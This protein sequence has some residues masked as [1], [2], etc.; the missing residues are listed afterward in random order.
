[1]KR[2]LK[3]VIKRDIEVGDHHRGEKLIEQSLCEEKV[4]IVLDDVDSHEQVDAL[5]S[6]L[7]W[8]GRGRRVIPTT[9]DEHILNVIKID[10][11]KIY[12]PQE[13]DHK[14][15]LQ[16]FRLHAFSRDPPPE[17]YMK[18]SHVECYSGGWPL[19]LEVLG[20]YLLDISG[21]EKWESTLQK[22]KEIPLE[23]VQRRLSY[24]NLED[25]YLKTIFL[26][27]AYFFIG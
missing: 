15:S 5:A 16:L 18:I 2:L 17:D 23:K 24:D 13:L 7:N 8:F 25:D 19:T 11:D 3:D 21:K 12:S 10:K 14:N 1:M 26:D 6:A 22:L 27:A 9:R 20:S 4:L